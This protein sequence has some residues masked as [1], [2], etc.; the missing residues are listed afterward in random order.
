VNHHLRRPAPA[1]V[2]EFK[3]GDIVTT[4]Y[5]SEHHNPYDMPSGSTGV[6]TAVGKY[7]IEVTYPVATYQT[8]ISG[9]ACYNYIKLSYPNDAVYDTY[10]LDFVEVELVAL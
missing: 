6:V 1:S 7:K 4:T 2:Y 8:Y 10:A 3:E 9:R 5:V